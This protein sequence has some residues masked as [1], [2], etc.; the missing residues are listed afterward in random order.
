MYKHFFKRLFDFIISLIALLLIGWFLIIITIWL[1]FANKGAGAFFFQERPYLKAAN[2]FVLPSYR[3]GFGMVLI[4]AGAMGLP[5][6]TT[7]ITG[8]NEIIIPGENGA[9]VEPRNED[10][11]YD[12]MN[13]WLDNLD[14]V[15]EMAGKAR[16][17]VED[18]YEC[19]KVWKGYS[20]LYKG[21]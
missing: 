3:E 6:I 15:S 17:L 2:A 21:L 18:R 11:L 12:E 20:T 4:E 10:A 1:H 13:K 5:C 8:C 14:L 7:N 16:K 9:I 19:H